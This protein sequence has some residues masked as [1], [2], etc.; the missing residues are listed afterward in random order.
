[1]PA[2]D[3]SSKRILLI[4]SS[5]NFRSTLRG[6][7][8]SLG[9]GHV[10]APPIR[11][12]LLDT[13]GDGGY[14]I[15][16]IGHNDRDRYTGLQILEEARYR[17]L[18][19]PTC[20]WILMTS[21]ASQESVLYAIEMRPDEVLTKPFTINEL[22]KRLH[23][24]CLRRQELEAIDRA[25]EKGALNRAIKLCDTEV[26][27]SSKNYDYTQLIK[28]QLLLQSEQYARAKPVFA[29][30]YWSTKDLM[31]GFWLATCHFHLG[32]YSEAQTL[33]ESLLASH[34]LLIPAYDLLAKIHEAKG[35]HED[36]C[37]VLQRA[38]V[39][40]PLA[41]ERQNEVGRLA[42]ETGQIDV[43]I[44]A[45]R[46]SISLGEKSCKASAE[47]FLRLANLHRYQAG[48]LEGRDRDYAFQE[49]EKLLDRVPRAFRDQPEVKL[50]LMLLKGQLLE[51]MGLED[52]AASVLDEAR[53]FSLGLKD[54]VDIEQQKAR[55]VSL[56]A[57]AAQGSP[58]APAA[59]GKRKVEHDP[60][61][62]DK[63]N[64]I[65]VRNYMAGKRTQAM[66]YFGMAMEYDATNGRALLNLAQLFLEAARDTP[67]RHDER[68]RMFDRYLRLAHRLTL[69]DA[70]KARLG[71]LV[72]LG[73]LETPQLAAGPLLTLIK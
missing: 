72:R 44:Q 39:R 52:E 2:V 4:D 71:E 70:E 10:D 69:E 73:R 67:S 25:I 65:G 51:D 13:I 57:M 15:I 62:S 26:S 59:Q 40:S 22:K 12:D 5:G 42:A 30:H 46:K 49:A 6:M 19:K 33:L 3:F 50:N 9:F 43:A 23:I 36:A 7:L 45:Y 1:M 18:I 21:D 68:R 24:L 34:E 29:S 37:R 58:P 14:D 11:D 54:V 31:P 20:A 47:P 56:K 48:D 66:R 8:T 63:V 38:I 35:E 16:L 41:V 61:M 17:G 53:E 64:R 55:L 32:Q 27:R 28:G 60:I